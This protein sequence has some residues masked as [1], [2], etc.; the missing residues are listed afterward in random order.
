MRYRPR[1]FSIND[2]FAWH[3][4]AELKLSPFFQRRPVW[5]PQARSYLID[6]LLEGYP[7]PAIQIRQIIDVNEQRTVR[8]VVDGQQRLRAIFDFLEGNL[9]ILPS[10]SEEYGGKTYEDLSDDDKDEFCCGLASRLSGD[11]P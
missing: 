8:E 6:T 10:Q 11:L 9:R 3:Q 7:I 5:S 4:K 2:L 1:V